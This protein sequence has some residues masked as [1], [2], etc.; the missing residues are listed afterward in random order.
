MDD[1]WVIATAFNSG[2]PP[3]EVYINL[4]LVTNMLRIDNHTEVIF[5]GGGSVSVNESPDNLIGAKSRR[6]W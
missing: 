6:A 4:S 1:P 3:R 2:S 5:S